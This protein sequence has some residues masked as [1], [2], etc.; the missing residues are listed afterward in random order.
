MT[1]TA[2]VI[3]NGISTLTTEVSNNTGADYY[4]DEFTITVKDKEGNVLTTLSR[5]VG[6]VILNGEV[7]AINTSSDIDLSKANSIEYS[8]KNRYI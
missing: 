1:N 8:I 6:G 7:R 5:Y 3:Q 4:V 2:L